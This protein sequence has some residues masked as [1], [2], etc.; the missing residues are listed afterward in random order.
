MEKVKSV[1][2]KD[3]GKVID[4]LDINRAAYLEKNQIKAH[5]IKRADGRVVFR[6]PADEKVQRLLVEYET[7]P[8]IRLL[9]F[10]ITLKRLRG[11]MLDIREGR[12]GNGGNGY[13]RYNESFG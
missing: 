9:D 10:V 5:L 6:F 8:E 11:R 2:E 13:G 7:N 4:L 12:N 3:T 1:V